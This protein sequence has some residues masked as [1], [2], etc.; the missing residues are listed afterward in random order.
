MNTSQECSIRC[1]DGYSY[2]SGETSIHCGLE[3]GLPSSDM[4]CEENL[5]EKFYLSEG[6]EGDE[7]YDSNMVPCY[8]GIQL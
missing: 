3:A 6:M 4:I 1:T 2:V 5:C 7:F 8:N